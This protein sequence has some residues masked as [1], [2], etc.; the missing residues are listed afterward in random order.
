MNI[1]KLLDKLGYRV[2]V[3]ATDNGCVVEFPERKQAPLLHSALVSVQ[4]TEDGV[5]VQHNDT[6]GT[7]LHSTTHKCPSYAQ[8]LLLNYYIM[9]MCIMIQYSLYYIKFMNDVDEE[10]LEQEFFHL[11]RSPYMSEDMEKKEAILGQILMPCM[12][13]GFDEQYKQLAQEHDVLEG[14]LAI[15]QAL[16]GDVD[17]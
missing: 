15:Q 12:I 17:E 13:H 11:I 5:Y 1:A 10:V 16:G 3:Y 2:I 7:E 4:Y 9:S 6:Y 8:R 14:F